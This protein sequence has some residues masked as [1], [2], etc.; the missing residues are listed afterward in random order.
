MA[1]KKRSELPTVKEADQIHAADRIRRT[2]TG[3]AWKCHYCGQFA[4]SETVD[5]KF[6]CRSHGGCTPRQ[7]DPVAQQVAHENFRPVPRPPGRPPRT[8]R[9]SRRQLLKVDEIFAMYKAQRL[10][11]DATDDD[12]LYLRAELEQRKRELKELGETLELLANINGQL[13]TVAES[14]TGPLEVQE[15]TREVNLLMGKRLSL[16]R[17]IEK[18]HERLIKLAKIRAETRLKNG[19]ANQ[20]GQF[21]LMIERLTDIFQETLPPDVHA[22]LQARLAKE[23]EALPNVQA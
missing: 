18:G 4:S 10:D 8:G 14:S 17:R 15:L 1:R 19:A 12:M 3:W 23:F 20:I 7:R 11:P 6:V 5:G 9:W 2:P 22:A 13:R 16:S 21:M